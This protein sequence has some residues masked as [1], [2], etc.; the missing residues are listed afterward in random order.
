MKIPSLTNW[1]TLD[2]YEEL[3]ALLSDSE[4]GSDQDKFRSLSKSIRNRTCCVLL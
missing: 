2:R 1:I 3:G 4:I